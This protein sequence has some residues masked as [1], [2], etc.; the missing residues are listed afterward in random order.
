MLEDRSPD[1][2]DFRTFEFS[3][4]QKVADRYH[5]AWGELTRRAG[6]CLLDAIGVTRGH[7]LL[8]VATG[9]GYVAASA[10]DRGAAVIGIDFSPHMIEKAG[11][12]FP[13]VDFRPGDAEHLPFPDA[14][15]DRVSMN[16]GMLHLGDP[17]RATNE[18]YRVLTPGGRFGFTV[19]TSP[20]EAAGFALLSAAVMEFG[21]PVPM[22]E[23]PDFYHFSRPDQCRASLQA[24]GFTATRA[25]LLDLRWRLAS[26]DELFP[27]YLHGTVRSGA[28]LRGQRESDRAKIEERVRR[29]AL[30]FREANGEIVIPMPAIVA[31][32]EKDG[33]N[34]VNGYR[35]PS[36]SAP[37]D[38]R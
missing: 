5:L 7:T 28:L 24:A 17:Q 15:F 34:P 33:R 37:P 19:W 35:A 16:F 4:W 10:A 18:A 31:W 29:T 8:D 25:E 27:A 11:E 3:G 22:P 20:D 13:R 12:L 36:A 21:Q 6:Q 23:G 38:G 30:Q 32:G 2:H 14:T 1:V 26:I 9:P